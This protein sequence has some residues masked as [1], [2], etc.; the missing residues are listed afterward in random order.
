MKDTSYL[1]SRELLVLAASWHL[2]SLLLERPRPEWKSE[3][4]RLAAEVS[5]PRLTGCAA[6]ADQASEEVYHRLFGPA[7]AI[8]PREVSYCGFEDPGRLLAQL[9]A[10]YHAFSFNPQREESIDHVS[11]EAGFV[12]Y[13][14]LKEAYARMRNAAA[15]AAIARDARERFLREHLARSARGMLERG[16]GLPAYLQNLL[17]WLNAGTESTCQ[18]PEA[19]I[20]IHEPTGPISR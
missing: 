2:A 20:I 18:P 19:S 16:V 8:S 1:D 3:I 10:F 12:G 5:D 15:S 17:S 6:Q 7:G 4:A 13:L 14:F 9:S 11:V